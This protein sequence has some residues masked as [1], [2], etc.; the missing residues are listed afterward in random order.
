MTRHLRRWGW[1]WLLLVLFV[2]SWV[3]QAVAQAAANDSA[4][5][6][7]AATFENWQSEFL[8]LTVQAGL[9]VGA[10]AV[11]FRKSQ[12]DQERMERKLDALLHGAGIDPEECG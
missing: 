4:S 12:E 7:W 11:G 2:V 5:E 6:F 3:A 8:Q 9:V 1:V 10:A